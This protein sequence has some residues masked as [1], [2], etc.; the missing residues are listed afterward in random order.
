VKNINLSS[1]EGTFLIPTPGQSAYLSVNRGLAR[2]GTSQ[3]DIVR[4]IRDLNPGFTMASAAK[5]A[6]TAA[7]VYCPDLL[8]GP[9]PGSGDGGNQ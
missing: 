8:A 9:N 3:L 2:S 5:F 7:S 6:H 1:S 4:D